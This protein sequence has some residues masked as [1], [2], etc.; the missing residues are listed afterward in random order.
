M[1]RLNVDFEATKNQNQQY[2]DQITILE[3]NQTEIL[4]VSSIKQ[5][6][7]LQSDYKG[8]DSD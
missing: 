3:N 6:Q 7:V 2:L 1:T 8:P 4:H 5:T